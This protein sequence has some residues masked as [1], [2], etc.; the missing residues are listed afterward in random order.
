MNSKSPNLRVDS[1]FHV[2]KA[3]VGI[4]Q[5][6]YV[7]AYDADIRSWLALAQTE[8]INGGVLI[9]PSFLGNDNTQMLDAMALAPDLLRG[10]VVVSPGVSPFLLKDWNARGVRGIRLNFAGVA[11]DMGVWSKAKL[12][13]DALLALGWHVEIHT[14]KGCLPQVLPF[15]PNELPVVIDHMAKPK[16]ASMHD[17][18]VRLLTRQL[19]RSVHIKLSGAYRLGGV[20]A[21]ELAQLWLSEL[22]ESALLWGSDWPCTNHE[23]LAHYSELLHPLT[24]WVGQ[25]CVDAV[26]STNPLKLYWR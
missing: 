22:G 20:M 25:S 23:S 6:R 5:S 26:L 7:P 13:W 21:Q 19:N 14:D 17:E 10:V 18:T 15:L 16:A 12:L 1:H 24:D 3:N 4:P 2:F 9:Q 8:G 11:H